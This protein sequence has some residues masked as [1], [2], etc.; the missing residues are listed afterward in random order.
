MSPPRAQCPRPA[1]FLDEEA[2]TPVIGSILILG[3][4]VL[5]IA[6]IM[7]WG[8]PA[9]Q[10]L[11]E[12]NAQYAMLGEFE[13]V[14]QNSL[15]LTITD[16]SRLPRVNLGSGEFM[17]EPGTRIAVT[18]VFAGPTAAIP[19]CRMDLQ[20][21]AAADDTQ[22]SIDV[23]DCLQTR[24]ETGSPGCPGASEAMCVRA[25]QVDGRKFTQ[26]LAESNS[27]IGS[28]T[29][30]LTLDLP[31]SFATGSWLV[32]LEDRPGGIVYA[33]TWVIEYQALHWQIN[34]RTDPF[35]RLEAGALFSGEGE[36]RFLEQAPPIAE[37]A[38]GSDELILRWPMLEGP[39]VDRSGLQ[40]LTVF[41]RLEDNL[42]RVDDDVRTVQYDFEGEF[43]S[44]WCMGLSFRDDLVDGGF[45]YRQPYPDRACSGSTH[46]DERYTIVYDRDAG[47]TPFPF[48]FTHV[49]IDVEI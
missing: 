47:T 13:E 10:I 14:R 17:V 22:V 37:Q 30:T 16:G 43:A 20:D 27:V 4:S 25:Y 3:I 31:T 6:A 39:A 23:V 41:L 5:G 32:R 9:L 46:D 29:G 11:E 34:G 33:E 1:R 28:G 35:L 45:A 2:I 48:A 44:A 18:T 24:V 38:F 19:D 15:A 49:Q 26:V 40:S 7:A 21:W 8:A 12:Q 36:R 42:L